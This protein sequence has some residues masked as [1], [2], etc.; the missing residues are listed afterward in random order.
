MSRFRN[1]LLLAL[2][3][4]AVWSSAPSV[5]AAEPPCDA[6]CGRVR[7]ELEVFTDWLAKH[8]ALGYI[9][10]VGWPDDVM[11]DGARW[12]ALAD[13]WYADADAAGLPV[14]AWATGEWWGTTYNLGIYEDRLTG[15]GVDTSNVQ[16]LVL[17]AH[18][19]TWRYRR[20]INVAGAEFGAPVNASTSAFSNAN[21]G[22]EGTAYHYDSQTTFDLLASRGIKIVRIPFRWERVQPR[23]RQ[24]LASAELARLRGVVGRA[25]AAGLEAVLDMH[26]YAGYYLYD[27]TK[28]VRRALGSNKVGKA[29]FVDVWRRLSSAFKGEGG[30]YAYGLM[31]EPTGMTA[32]AGLSPARRWEIIS[33]AAVDAI[34]TNGDTK[35]V[36]VAGYNWSGV[37][38]W[39]SQHPKPWISS[40]RGA[41]RYE[42]HHYWDRDNSGDYPD[43]YDAEVIDAANR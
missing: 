1:A 35:T 15:A 36:M 20:G 28:G 26:N 16:A 31:N 29:E 6:L 38:Q 32:A 5:G 33:Q 21:P 25:K 18:P 4:L 40:V 7:G 34:R 19:T 3:C 30:V 11:G 39:T 27:G 42:A 2:A 17:E 43:T 14:T 8:G 24:A 9:G 22:T 41:I 12:N 23:L 37:Q 13:A 10:E